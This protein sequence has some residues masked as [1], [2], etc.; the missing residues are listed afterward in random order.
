MNTVVLSSQQLMSIYHVCKRT[1]DLVL[2]QRDD[3]RV[4]VEDEKSGRQWLVS[5]AGEVTQLF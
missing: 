5:V 2:V 3:R 1:G 4:L